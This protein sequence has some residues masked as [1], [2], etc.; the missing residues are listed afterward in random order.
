MSLVLSVVSGEPPSDAGWIQGP[1]FEDA[2]GPVRYHEFVHAAC[3]VCVLGITVLE[4][5]Q[6]RPDKGHS[7]GT[8]SQEPFAAQMDT[9]DGTFST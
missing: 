4:L 7:S 5:I 6:Y 9:Y 2:P 8:F 3:S 1:P